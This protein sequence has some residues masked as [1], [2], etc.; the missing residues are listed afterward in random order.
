[1]RIEGLLGLFAA[2][3]LN[4]DAAHRVTVH[5]SRNGSHIGPEAE[6]GCE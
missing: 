2:I 6:R 3:T 4:I 1:M 5:Q